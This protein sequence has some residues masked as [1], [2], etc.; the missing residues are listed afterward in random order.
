MTCEPQVARQ[1]GGGGGG[2][3]VNCDSTMPRRSPR[4]QLAA[5]PKRRPSAP[6]GDRSGTQANP[7]HGLA[8]RDYVIAPCEW[9]R[10]SAASKHFT[11]APR[12]KYWWVP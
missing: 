11:R 7:I 12:Q 4:L 3:A 8:R 9:G 1:D 10:A 6:P 5:S 2:E